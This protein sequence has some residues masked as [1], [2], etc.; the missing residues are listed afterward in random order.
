MSCFAEKS[1]SKVGLLINTIDSKK[2]DIK[3]ILT[4]KDEVGQWRTGW[5]KN[6]RDSSFA[7]KKPK[8]PRCRQ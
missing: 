7:L 6:H 3:S 2:E 1:F 5:N 8:G 4:A